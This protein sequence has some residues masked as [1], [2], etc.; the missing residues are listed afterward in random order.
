MR[1]DE[2]DTLAHLPFLLRGALVWPP[3]HG[4]EVVR[5]AFASQPPEVQ[6][7]ATAQAQLLRF[8]GP[9]GA[10]PRYVVLPRV[11]PEAL[12]EADFD[13]LAAGPYAL[14][15]AQALDF[16]RRAG[17]RLQAAPARL[18]PA[19]RWHQHTSG[20]P[21]AFVQAAFAGLA[22]GFDE[23]LGGA[24]VDR[25]L[26]AW[27]LPGRE[28]LDGW[29]ALPAGPLPSLQATLAAALAQEGEAVLLH[30]ERPARLKA[31][32]TR[33]LHVTA[34]SSP[35]VPW[36]SAL[37][38]L[39]T[40]SV[41]VVKLPREALFS[42]ALLALAL[43][44]AEPG[45]PLTRHLSI[46]YWPGG[47]R[48]VEDPL[49]RPGAFDRV[50][51]WGAPAAVASVQARAG[52]TRVVAFNPRYGVSLIGRE[53]FAALAPA[54]FAA[55][56][57][58]LVANQ[59]A[60][61]ASLVHYVEGDLA[62]A[63][64]WAEQVRGVLARWD[65]LAPRPVA[66]P[67]RAAVHL[68]RRGRYALADWRLNAPG[69]DFSSGVVVLPGEFEPL[70]HPLCRLVVVRPVARLEDALPALHAGVSTV[71]VY[72]EA[73]RLAL[74]DRLAARGVTNVLPLGHAERLVPGAAHDGALVLSQLV[75]WKNG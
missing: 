52:F 31:M 71:G 22:L 38:L 33:Q 61:T 51:V 34:G 10:S 25:E 6:H 72:P 32:P 64:R 30:A 43:A 67:S 42:G 46:V 29:V 41:G 9:A 5:A 49:L 47:E 27:G 44:E 18:S 8:P 7:L 53:A 14:S 24:L 69:G 55:V 16:L 11:E 57:D 58:S 60:C 26:G 75:E 35:E 15:T 39:L 62:A 21:E 3:E 36:V 37:R 13:A 68:L 56:A 12:V 40:R 19:A 73:R 70:D 74:C 28:F 59:Q 2:T 65:A 66:P 1:L 50:V 17:E 45:H 63:E 20:Q 23:A 54:A 48:A 4:L